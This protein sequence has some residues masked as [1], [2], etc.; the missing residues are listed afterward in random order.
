MKSEATPVNNY[1]N[2][3]R[4]YTIVS[5]FVR[6]AA[7]GQYYVAR[8]RSALKFAISSCAVFVK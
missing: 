4:P 3:I 2:P 8:D 7:N 1:P 5:D 6:Q